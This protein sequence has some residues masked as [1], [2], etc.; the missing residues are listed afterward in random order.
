MAV[1]SWHHV[2]DRATA[3]LPWTAAVA[4]ALANLAA[5]QG[6]R[7]ARCRAP[8]GESTQGA[9]ASLSPAETQS[10]R[11]IGRRDAPPA[12]GAMG[13]AGPRGRS[14]ALTTTRKA[15][16][17]EATHEGPGRPR[18]GV[19]GRDR[20]R[21][22]KRPTH[23][24]QSKAA[25]KKTKGAGKAPT[26]FDTAMTG[27]AAR[28]RR[29]EAGGTSPASREGVARCGFAGRIQPTSDLAAGHLQ[30]PARTMAT[31]TYHL[32]SLVPEK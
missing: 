16:P 25:P 22:H 21:G 13:R 29:C 4:A 24:D 5:L 26:P 30:G 15:Q 27:H 32:L 17:A 23:E 19:P 11:G 18:G 2:V 1:S 28:A 7:P 6:G 3:S 31:Y 8:N 20:T 9:V 14:G 12:G 10:A